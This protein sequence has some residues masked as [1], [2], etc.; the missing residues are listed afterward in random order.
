MPETGGEDLLGSCDGTVRE[1][2]LENCRDTPPGKQPGYSFG[3]FLLDRLASMIIG[4]VCIAGTFGMCLIL[5]CGTQGSLFVAGFVLLC[6]VVT[7]V[8]QYLRG[9]RFW[10]SIVDA[11]SQIQEVSEASEMVAAPSTLEGRLA[12]EL[13]DSCQTLSA[14][15]VAAAAQSATDYRRYIELWIHEAK[16]PLASAKLV[17]GR[18]SG[19]EGDALALELERLDTSIDQVLYYARSTS[20]ANDYAI[21][22]VRLA[23]AVREACKRHMRFLIEQGATPC[24]EIPEDEQVLTDEPWLIFMV[25]QVTVNAAQY[26]ATTVTFRAHVED[27]ET[28]SER[29][30]LEVAD[31]GCGISAADLPRVFDRAFTGSNGRERPNATGMGLYL[32]ALMCERLGIGLQV[33]SEEGRG[34]RVMFSFPHDSRRMTERMTASVR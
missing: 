25:G 11:A 4:L 31:D 29:T 15:K 5:G 28:A 32:V 6:A 3:S 9:R 24:I 12:E 13:L 1:E 20:V 21:R 33:A 17:A 23:A 2:W 34:T 16:T 30:V 18:L 8:V 14:S 26:G 27:A 10:E 19:E 7:L 22:R